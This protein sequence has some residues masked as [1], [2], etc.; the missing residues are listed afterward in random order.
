M[1]IQEFITSFTNVDIARPS[2]FLVNIL[3][4]TGDLLTYTNQLPG[5]FIFRCENA[6][7]PGRT[8][9]TVDQKFGSNPTQKYP[10]HTS[11]NDIS[12]SFLVSDDMSEKTFFDIWME[13]INPSQ[14]FDFNYKDNYSATVTVYQFDVADKL[15]YAVNLLNAYPIVVNQLD[16]DWS[17]DGAHK[18]VVVFAYDYWQ[19]AGM[20]ALNNS[21]FLPKSAI[22]SLGIGAPTFQPQP[23]PTVQQVAAPVDNIISATTLKTPIHG[24]GGDLP[25]ATQNQITNGEVN[26]NILG[27]Y[28]TVG[29]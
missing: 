19:M 28:T 5:N 9:G 14:S 25:Q 2:K 16:L 13:Y 23:P 18:L 17:S 7:L 10:I 8:F 27:R 12:L 21:D 3:P 29:K 6:E 11:Y 24:L 22:S 20:D 4:N 1:A 15:S 26:S